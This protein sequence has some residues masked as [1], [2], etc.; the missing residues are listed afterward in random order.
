MP[1]GRGTVVC[2]KSGRDKGYFLA[3]VS[4]DD[5][6]ALVCDGKERRLERPKKKNLKHISPTDIVLSEEQ[7][8]TNKSLKHALNDF[9]TNNVKGEI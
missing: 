6:F 8:K 4:S 5:R 7:L 9:R 2:S 3:V 1:Y